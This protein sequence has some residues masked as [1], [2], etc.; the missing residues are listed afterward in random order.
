MNS[1]KK[2]LALML[3]IGNFIFFNLHAQDDLEI[4]KVFDQY[5]EKKGVIMVELSSEMLEDYDFTLFKSITIKNNPPAADFIRKC[6]SKDEIGAKKVKHVVSNGIP[7]TI[8]LQL[9]RKGDAFRLILFNES[10]KPELKNTLIYIESKNDSEEALK[11]IIK[12]K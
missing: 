5:G 10:L 12:K 6:L 4:K 2:Y 1:I 8:Y 11:L 7:T 3:V 9:P